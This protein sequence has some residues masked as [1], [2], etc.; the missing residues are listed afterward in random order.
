VTRIH[1]RS[2]ALDL[3]G[4]GSIFALGWYCHEWYCDQS[5]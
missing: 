1:W 4:L 5:D 2:L 3:F